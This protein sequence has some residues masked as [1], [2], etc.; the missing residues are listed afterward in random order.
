MV[1]KITELATTPA[2]AEGEAIPIRVE[3]PA[4]AA[5]ELWDSGLPVAA[6]AGDTLKSVADTYH[7]P[8][9]SLAEINSVSTRAPLSEGQQIIVPRHLMPTAVP[10]VASAAVSSYAPVG[11]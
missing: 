7:V 2:A 10:N 5:V 4:D 11:R 9:W 6:H 3:V 1:S 8:L